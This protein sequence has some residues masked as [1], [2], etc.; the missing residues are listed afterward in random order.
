MTQH[1]EARPFRTPASQSSQLHRPRGDTQSHLCSFKRCPW[2]SI[3]HDGLTLLFPLSCPVRCARDQEGYFAD[4]LYKSMTGA[5]TDEETLIHIFVTRA[6]VRHT[7]L[8]SGGRQT[9]F[10]TTVVI[11]EE[12]FIY[13]KSKTETAFTFPD[14]VDDPVLCFN[15]FL[16]VK[17]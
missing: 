9:L 4:R 5:G 16:F 13:R 12:F 15:L 6:E 10:T 2:Y 11:D 1:C 7:R 14:F 3:K 8:Q 17:I